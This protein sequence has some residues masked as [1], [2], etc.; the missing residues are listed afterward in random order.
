MNNPIKRSRFSDR[1]QLPE[2]SS[3]NEFGLQRSAGRKTRVENYIFFCWLVS[4]FRNWVVQ[5]YQEFI[6]GTSRSSFLLKVG[7]SVIFQFREMHGK[8][9]TKQ[10]SQFNSELFIRSRASNISSR[11]SGLLDT[12]AATCI[13]H[14]Y[15][16]LARSGEET[17][18]C[19][20]PFDCRR[21]LNILQKHY[22]S[23]KTSL[24][25]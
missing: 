18:S 23:R 9:H 17:T 10:N 8:N 19:G 20:Q 21:Q 14:H 25:H 16:M 12:T 3:Q 2:E 15:D 4:R 13:Q 24:F 6:G 5:T 11:L 22:S 1:E 7:S